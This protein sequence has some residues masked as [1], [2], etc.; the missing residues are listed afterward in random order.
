MKDFKPKAETVSSQ[1]ALGP[2]VFSYN[3]N[4]TQDNLPLNPAQDTKGHREL[5]EHYQ[6]H[7]AKQNDKIW[8]QGGWPQRLYLSCICGLRC[9]VYV[10]T[11]IRGHHWGVFL[12]L[13]GHNLILSW[14]GSSKDISFTSGV[15]ES[16]RLSQLLFI[17]C[18][19]WTIIHL[20]H[21]FT[22]HFKFSHQN[23]T[24]RCVFSAY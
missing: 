15:K 23:S 17:L 13:W 9:V 7:L 8:T 21:S 22:S 14:F 16:A 12:P 5:K 2:R 1:A 24:G 10:L 20:V 11:E 6:N 3:R 4:P 18:L 19:R